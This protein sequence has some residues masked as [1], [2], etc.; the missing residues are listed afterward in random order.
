MPRSPNWQSK[1]MQPNAINTALN[2]FSAVV[3]PFLGQTIVLAD[4]GFRA[5]EGV[6]EHMKLCPKGTWNETD[7]R[8]DGLV[9]GHHRV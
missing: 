3:T 4:F 7:V 2:R 5:K 6:P 1:Q 9:D 8:G